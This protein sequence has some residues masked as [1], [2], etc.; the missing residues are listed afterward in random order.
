MMGEKVEGWA[1]GSRRGRKAG[2]P[3]AGWLNH[4]SCE[5]DGLGR[6]EHEEECMKDEHRFFLV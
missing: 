6:S 2:D 1:D 5:G 3:V 4:S